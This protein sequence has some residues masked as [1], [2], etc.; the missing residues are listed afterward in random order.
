VAA[1]HTGLQRQREQFLGVH[2]ILN[3]AKGNTSG[4]GSPVS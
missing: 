4:Q 1:I 3:S 2:L